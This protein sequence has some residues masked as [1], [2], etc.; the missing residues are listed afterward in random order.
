[1]QQAIL[2]IYPQAARIIDMQS[3]RPGYLLFPARLTMQATTGETQVCVLKVSMDADKL[4]YEA[5]VLRALADLQL[6]VPQVLAGPATLPSTPEPLTVMLISELPGQPLPWIG[7]T[8]LATA[9]RTCRLVHAAVDRLHALTP[10]VSAHPIATLVPSRTLESEVQTIRARRSDWLDVPKFSDALNLVEA[11]LPQYASP[12]VFSN[13]D[14]N[15]LNFLVEDDELVGWID[16]EYACFEDP[17]IGFAKFFL[18]ADD[19]AGWGAGAK[20]GLVER[21]LYAHQVAPTAFLVR[22]VLRGL[23]HLQDSSPTD[24]LPFML[25][26]ISDAVHRLGAEF[27]A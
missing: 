4:A 27:D 3:F 5:R 25:Q 6:P 9:D 1:L 12:L 2:Q 22:L 17:Y 20:A 26:V 10:A 23:S 19:A 11:A 15:P 16:F 13:G 21:Y 18:W 24:P 7:L 14:Y 8:D